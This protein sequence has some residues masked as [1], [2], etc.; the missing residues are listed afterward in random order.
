MACIGI[1][2]LRYRH[3][4]RPAYRPLHG[5]LATG[6]PQPVSLSF[7]WLLAVRE[8]VCVCGGGGYPQTGYGTKPAAAWVF[9]TRHLLGRGW[10]TPPAI[11]RELI[12]TARRSERQWKTIDDCL[13]KILS[14]GGQVKGQNT[15]FSHDRLPRLD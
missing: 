2:G 6:R 13:K 1:L 11:T 10:Y 14:G 15:F 5:V 7:H 8:C 12:A 3:L 9:R 4:A